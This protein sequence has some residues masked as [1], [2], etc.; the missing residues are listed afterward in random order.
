MKKATLLVVNICIILSLVVF[1]VLYS[2]FDRKNDYNDKITNFENMTLAMERITENY[3]QGEQ[4]ICDVWANYI[5]GRDMTL[6]EA[7]EFIRASHVIKNTS[8]HLIYTDTFEGMS[9]RS[10]SVSPDNFDVSYKNVDIFGD[11]E[12]IDEV[13]Q[14]INISRAYTNP[15]NGEQS[16]A[17]INRISVADGEK[18]ERKSA[19]LLRI[20]PVS[21]LEDK[22]VFPQT[23]FNDA[24]ICIINS[25]GDYIIKGK[26]FKSNNFFEFYRSYNKISN[27]ALQ[28]LKDA[29]SQTTGSF[30]MKDSKEDACV[31]AH[32]PVSV[33]NGWVMLN[34]IEN[35]LISSKSEDWIMIIVI[36][37]GLLTLLFVNAF[38]MQV[39]N[40]RLK[41]LAKKADS[42]NKAKTDFLSTMSHDIRTPMNA[43]IG[44]TTIAEKTIDDRKSV[45]ES[46]RKI[47]LASNHLLTLI[48]DILDISKVESGKSTLNPMTFSVVDSVENLVNIS[49]PMIKEKDIDFNIRANH[50][51]KEYLF[52]DQMRLNQIYINILSNAVKYT[53][54]GGNISVDITQE[55]SE[56]PDH[57]RMIYRV[58][59]T[60]MGMSPEFMKVMYEPFSRQTDSRV[61]RIQGTGLGLA[62][63]K[64]MVDL[65]DGTIDCRSELGK[66]TTFTVTIDIPVADKQPDDM[67]LGPIDVLT[68]DD[69]RDLLDAAADTLL[70]LGVRSVEKAASGAEAL[71]LVGKRKADGKTYDVVIVD[72]KMPDMDGIETARHI[73]KE[74]GDDVPILLSSAYDPGDIESAAKDAG[75]N[76]SLAK[77]LFR[78]TLYSRINELLAVRTQSAESEDDYSD[79]AGTNILI[80]EDND[81]NWEIINALLEMYG[82]GSERAENGKVCVEKLKAAPAGTFDLVFMD[83]QMPEMNGLDA[84]R[85]IRDLGDERAANIPIIAMTA[86]AFSEDVAECMR[87]GMNGHIAKPVDIGLVIKEIR[88]IKEKRK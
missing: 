74:L 17:F 58:A 23:E 64:K 43:I 76:A 6:K 87:A 73:R 25:N 35:S 77:P 59:D 49:Q 75:I 20:V 5:N 30:T 53:P 83:V 8:A 86:D 15:M 10:N 48:N 37:V 1:I 46:L 7:T 54:S 28:E 11:M 27:T 69:D 22:W 9:T 55:Q 80:A 13:G 44:L 39:L 88:K 19:L 67:E 32:T 47:S 57:V 61:N 41:L 4:S 52:A 70:S 38:Y 21:E 71:E 50:I 16:I 12:W 3:L 68:V 81:I 24:E 42:A 63:I 82:V 2:H 31:I 65:M 45:S 60:G 66:G 33:S 51:E 84:T 72:W 62:I 34:Y 36:S 56:K 18:G 78:S 14:T 79:I 40:N 29:T 85:A 26:N